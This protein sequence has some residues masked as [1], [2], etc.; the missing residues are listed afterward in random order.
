MNGDQSLLQLRPI[1]DSF[2]TS[3]LLPHES[4]S[5]FLFVLSVVRMQQ[6]E[7]ESRTDSSRLLIFARRAK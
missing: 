6:I 3:L 4:E 7:F 5:R 2:F 1:C